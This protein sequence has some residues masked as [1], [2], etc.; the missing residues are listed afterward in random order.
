MNP[1]VAGLPRPQVRSVSQALLAVVAVAVLAAGVLA[2]S[3]AMGLP[4]FVPRLSVINPT[5][6][7]VEIDVTGRGGGSWLNLGGVPRE[8][9]KPLY[10]LIDQGDQWLFRFHYAGVDAGEMSV[11]RDD[12]RAGDW[13]V[14][15][16]AAVGDRLRAG[17]VSPSA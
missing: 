14:T 4:T 15:I 9:T 8:S 3:E 7:D 16:P 12:L 11:R 2:A 13:R 6:Y 1:T 10:E 5:P 17:G